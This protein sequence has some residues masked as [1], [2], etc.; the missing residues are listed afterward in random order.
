MEMLVC[1]IFDRVTGVYSEPL[2]AIN[3]AS[4]VRRFNFIMANS[5]MVSSDCQLFALGVFE[6]DTGRIRV[7]SDP[8]FICN[9]EVSLNEK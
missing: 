8:V 5:Q 3:E 2:F 1:S 6:S 7:N 9:Y 4:A